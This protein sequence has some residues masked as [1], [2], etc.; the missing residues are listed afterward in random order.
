MSVAAAVDF[1][2]VVCVSSSI[3][4]DGVY[5]TEFAPTPVSP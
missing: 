1:Y 3:I 2:P 4:P 5:S